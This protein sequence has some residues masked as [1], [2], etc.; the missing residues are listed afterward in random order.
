MKLNHPDYKLLWIALQFVYILAIF[1][2]VSKVV[3]KGHLTDTSSNADFATEGH[4]EQ[5]I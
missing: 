4:L 1:M 3:R 2:R 5:I